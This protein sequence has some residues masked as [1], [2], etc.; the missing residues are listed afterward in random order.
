MLPDNRLT[1]TAV[2]S[3]WMFNA[4]SVIGSNF[5][6]AEGGIGLQNPI[7]GVT[8][9]LWKIRVYQNKYVY[10]ESLTYPETLIHTGEAISDI[11]LAFD[12]N[13]NYYFAFLDKGECFLSWFDITQAKQVITSFGMDIV[14]PVVE[15]DDKRE[16]FYSNAD[17]VFSYIRDNKLYHRLQ[18]ERFTIERLLDEGPYVGIAKA[19]M[20]KGNRFQY[21]L[22]PL[23]YRDE[24]CNV[25]SN[26]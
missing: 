16:M 1:N 6:F 15:L 25:L 12:V 22:I 14:T 11:T 2:V 10:L 8:G 18:R 24:N 4:D 7:Q 17:V 13:M 3:D 20:N 19:G 26:P 9:Q 21:K 23:L 5:F